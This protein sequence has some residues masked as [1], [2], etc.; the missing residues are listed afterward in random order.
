MIK[1]ME[2]YKIM[3]D[4]LREDT[5]IMDTD[6]MVRRIGEKIELAAKHRQQSIQYYLDK[7]RADFKEIVKR[8]RNEGY[9][10][11]KIDESVIEISW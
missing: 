5:E 11:K 3:S 2:A 6:D 8:V 4:A 10:V 7:D 1:A 9:L